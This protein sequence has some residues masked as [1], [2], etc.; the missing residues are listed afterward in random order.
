MNEQGEREAIAATLYG[1]L[2]GLV[3][4]GNAELISA[5]L[6]GKKFRRCGKAITPCRYNR[7]HSMMCFVGIRITPAAGLAPFA[8]SKR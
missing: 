4:Q 1:E 6:P 8:D 5:T 3:Y 2:T 7:R